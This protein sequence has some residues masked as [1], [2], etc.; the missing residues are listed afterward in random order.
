[1][2]FFI[3]NFHLLVK[4]WEF[5]FLTKQKY[6]KPLLNLAL[7]SKLKMLEPRW[8]ILL[9]SKMVVKWTFFTQREEKS[10]FKM[11][12][13]EVSTMK[14]TISI[15]KILKKVHN[16]YHLKKYHKIK[17][18]LEGKEVSLWGD[19]TKKFLHMNIKLAIMIHIKVIYKKGS[20]TRIFHKNRLLANK[21]KLN[22]LIAM[23]H[24][25]AIQQI[26]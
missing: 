6:G 10:N 13:L 1:M 5:W 2:I 20:T 12:I 14:T 15:F 4:L 22:H 23:F 7:H 21:L 25:T 17:Y 19:N 18:L 16:N 3:K 26:I 9:S 8:I 24:Q 11:I